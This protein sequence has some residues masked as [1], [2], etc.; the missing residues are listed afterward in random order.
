MLK[1]PFPREYLVLPYNR[2]YISTFEKVDRNSTS[3]SKSSKQL[4]TDHEEANMHGFMR[5]N[6][7]K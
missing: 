1:H 6:I 3:I 2:K 4:L 7:F 5:E